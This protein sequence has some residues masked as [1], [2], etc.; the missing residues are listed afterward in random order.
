MFRRFAAEAAF[1]KRLV[2]V[3]GGYEDLSQAPYNA[4]DLNDKLLPFTIDIGRS[5]DG[6][7][8]ALSHQGTPSAIGYKRSLATEHLGTDDPDEIAKMFASKEKFLKQ[9]KS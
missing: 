7:I 8:R 1:V 6:K 9:Q 5:E 3:D 4:E 2:N